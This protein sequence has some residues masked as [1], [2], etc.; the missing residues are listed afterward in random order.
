MIIKIFN[1]LLPHLPSAFSEQILYKLVYRARRYKSKVEEIEFFKSGELFAYGENLFAHR[2]GLGPV[3]VL[4][5]GWGGASFQWYK[6]IQPLVNSGYSVVVPDIASHGQ[7]HGNQIGFDVFMKSLDFL[8]RF[9]NDNE[10]YAYI[11]HSAGGLAMM[12][13]RNPFDIR[14]KNYVCIATPSYPYPPIKIAQ[15]KIQLTEQLVKL[16]K[17]SLSKQFGCDWNQITKEAFVKDDLSK[18]LLIYDRTDRYLD[19]GDAENIIKF[20]P[21]ADI[22][23]T[24]GIGHEK[25][26]QSSQVAKKII[27]FLN[28][29]N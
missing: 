13:A 5:H 3:V 17:F 18:L 9:L 25:L 2:W 19:Q 23:F 14:A 4:V 12:A 26:I 20:W 29:E 27:Q 10:I 11:G 1:L 15:K 28:L 6:F 7:S 21:N 16:F 22:F 24:S 8:N